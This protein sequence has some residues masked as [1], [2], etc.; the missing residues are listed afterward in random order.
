MKYGFIGL[1][2]MAGA[3]LTGMRESEQFAKVEIFG[4]DSIPEKVSECEKKFGIIPAASP[5][6]LAGR[7]DVVILAVKPQVLT[8][9]LPE[10]SS[11]LDRDKTLISIA[12]GKEISFYES[13]LGKPVPFIRVMPNI[14]AE[15]KEAASALCP[16]SF[17]DESRLMIARGIF[18]TVGVVFDLPEKYF[19]AFTALSGSSVAFVFLYVDALSRAAVRAGLPRDLAQNIAVQAVLG[20]AKLMASSDEHPMS[21]TDKVC[22]PNGTTIEGILELQKLGFESSVHQAFDAVLKKDE[23]IAR[24]K[25]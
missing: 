6:E 13:A 20:S 8:E 3:I 11:A 10:I 24:G 16:G 12:A 14:N 19:G 5:V 15:V 18:E 1:G 4:S 23:L 22:S 21:L 2:N 7:T 17:A 25:A 9:I